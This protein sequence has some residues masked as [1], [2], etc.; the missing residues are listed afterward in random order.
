MF[1]D[2]T[3]AANDTLYGTAISYA[4]LFAHDQHI[5]NC[6]FISPLALA[7]KK[8]LRRLGNGV[9]TVVKSIDNFPLQ[10]LH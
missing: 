3:A 7:L 4:K 1:V 2:L 5:R 10:H 9:S 8:K 6:N